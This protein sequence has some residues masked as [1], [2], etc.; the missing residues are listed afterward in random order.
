MDHI[1]K[2]SRMRYSPRENHT[3]ERIIG[4]IFGSI[5]ILLG[6]R[7]LFKMLGANP[8]NGFVNGIYTITQFLVGFFE[9]I[10]SKYITS[11]VEPGAVFESATLI[12]MVVVGLIGWAVMKVIR[13]RTGDRA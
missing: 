6:I 3:V 10:F 2:P 12:A 9:G 4:A 7:L 5:E 11:P 13:P 1:V 8:A